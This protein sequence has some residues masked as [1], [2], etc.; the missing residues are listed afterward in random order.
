VP[1]YT[2]AVAGKIS[3]AAQQQIAL[4]IGIFFSL[5]PIFM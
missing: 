2:P 5:V 1:E 4:Y 3:T